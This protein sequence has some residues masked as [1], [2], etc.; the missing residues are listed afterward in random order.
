MFSNVTIAEWMGKSVFTITFIE[1]RSNR[2]EGA[3][4]TIRRH[5]VIYTDFK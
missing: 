5:T 4:D 2:Q 1:L 3:T